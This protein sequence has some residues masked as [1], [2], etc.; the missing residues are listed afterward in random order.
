ME[1]NR[2]DRNESA[3]HKQQRGIPPLSLFVVLSVTH[4]IVAAFI[5]RSALFFLM[6]RAFSCA[7][8]FSLF[9]VSLTFWRILPF[10]SLIP[11]SPLRCISLSVARA[12]FDSFGWR[13]LSFLSQIV[14]CRISIDR[15]VRLKP[16]LYALGRKVVL[17]FT[18]YR[19]RPPAADKR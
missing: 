7:V 19:D 18:C 8:F 9:S 15:V 3:Q 10:L 13:Y 6:R 14:C 5:P 11:V 12:L 16:S 2:I 4:S 1:W 17:P